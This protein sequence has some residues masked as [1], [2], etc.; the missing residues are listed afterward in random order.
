MAVA[1]D[2]LADITEMSHVVFV[3]KGGQIV[4]NDAIGQ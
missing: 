2:P 1:G 4:R 3:M